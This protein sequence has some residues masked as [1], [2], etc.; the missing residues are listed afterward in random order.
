M[1]VNRDKK[2]DIKE[3]N[4]MILRN[5]RGLF[6]GKSWLGHTENCEIIDIA[7]LNG[8]TREE[9]IERSRREVD[10]HISHL[11]AEHGLQISKNNDVYKLEYYHT[12]SNKALTDI[13]F[14]TLMEEDIEAVAKFCIVQLEDKDNK[15]KWYSIGIDAINKNDEEVTP[16]DESKGFVQSLLNNKV[17]DSVNFGGGFKIISVKKYLSE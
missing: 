8:A 14:R 5:K 7:L 9:L 2:N 10:G 15:T 17:G 3:T 4:K 12:A 13:D 6:I 1:T 11:R 16:L